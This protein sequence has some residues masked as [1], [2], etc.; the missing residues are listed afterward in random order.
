MDHQLA[1]KILRSADDETREDRAVRL[2]WLERN[3][4]PTDGHLLPG[5]Y[6]A[7]TAFWEA[8]ACFVS[9]QYL[10]T[11]LLAQT[12]LE[13]LLAGALV[14]FAADEK[15]HRLSAQQLFKRALGKGLL[16]EE[17]FELFDR[18]RGSRNPHAHP[19]SIDDPKSLMR[20][21][22][23]THTPPDEIYYRDAEAAIVALRSLLDRRP[24]AL[25]PLVPFAEE[26]AHERSDLEI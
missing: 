11:I 16:T 26:E 7:A 13:H 17:E 25:G 15:V 6:P 12:C 3:G 9:G 4:Q 19:R 23:D 1:L 10:A 20:R 24:F 22:M 2:S 18:L 21:M 14:I 5:G 8:G